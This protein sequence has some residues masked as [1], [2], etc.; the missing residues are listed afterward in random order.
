MRPFARY[1][2]TQQRCDRNFYCV[3]W[4]A[5][6]GAD[7]LLAASRAGFSPSLAAMIPAGLSVG[8]SSPGLAPPPPGVDARYAPSPPRRASAASAA[9]AS[10]MPALVRCSCMSC[11]SSPWGYCTRV[12]AAMAC[13]SRRRSGAV[14]ASLAAAAVLPLAAPPAVSAMSSTATAWN[15]AVQ[16][17]TDALSYASAHLPVHLLASEAEAQDI[18]GKKFPF[19]ELKREKVFLVI[20]VASQ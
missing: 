16:T 10:R 17:A 3:G 13:R 12:A 11:S 2:V 7:I 9:A 15:S 1:L 14:A 4:L 19:T 18:D 5:Y 8:A 6:V 20:N